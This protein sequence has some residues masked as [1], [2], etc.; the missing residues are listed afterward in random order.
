MFTII[1]EVLWQLLQLAAGNI[2]QCDVWEYVTEPEV[3]WYEETGAA[4]VEA[5]QLGK[6]FYITDGNRLSVWMFHVVHL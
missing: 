2:E 4:E 6:R 1:E 3:S 5:L